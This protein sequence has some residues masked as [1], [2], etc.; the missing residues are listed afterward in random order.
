MHLWKLRAAVKEETCG[1]CGPPC[2]CFHGVASGSLWKEAGTYEVPGPVGREEGTHM[3]LLKV[4][5]VSHRKRC[6]KGYE[7]ACPS[8]PVS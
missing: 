7:A 8:C 4:A 5:M 6:V 1:L 2:M 3:S